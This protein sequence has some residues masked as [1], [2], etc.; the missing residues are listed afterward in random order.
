MSSRRDFLRATATITAA[1]ALASP[2]AP[3]FAQEAAKPQA[4][5]DAMLTRKIPATGEVLPAMGFG[6]YAAMMTDDTGEAT[7]AAKAEL[8]KAFYDAGGRVVDTAPSYGNAEEVIGITSTM[9]GLNDKIFIT[10]KVLEREG[11][12]EAGV[13]SFERSFQRLQRD[14]TTKK[15]EVMQCHNFINWDTHLKTMREWKEKGQFRYI[16]VTHYQNH[17]HEQLERILKR[18]KVDFLQINYSAPEPQ[19][20]DRLLPAA[21][22]LGVAVLIN[23]PFVGG[24]VI[25]KAK[26]KPL[27]DFCKPFA[28]SWAQALLKFCLAHDAVTCVIPATGK[29]EHM[30]DN[31]QAGRGQLPDSSECEQLKKLFT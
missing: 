4:D 1:A 29:P 22:D 9:L 15:I 5:S 14:K 27:P 31:M 26:Q 17:A 28:S 3:L 20:A 16:G 25:R 11:G 23:R 13:K 7:I 21:R 6:T 18:D 2:V 8:L 24:D 12:A 10:T 30:R 19:A